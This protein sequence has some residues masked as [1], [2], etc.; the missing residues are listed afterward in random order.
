M[1]ADDKS[2]L[3][4]FHG[5]PWSTSLKLTSLFV[6]LVLIGVAIAVGRTG[7]WAG[8][9]ASSASLSLLVGMLLF[10][11][12]GYAVEGSALVVRRLL[13]NTRLSLLGLVSAK[14]DPLAMESSL[15]TFGNGGGFSFTGRYRNKRLGSYR[16]LVT[17]PARSVVLR[18]PERTVVVSRGSPEAFVRE[19]LGRV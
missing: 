12:R 8:W 9:L 19:L 5:A 4:G 10:T 13:W 1:K 17:D 3:G 6:S 15:R 14:A 18:W 7:G 16:A 2:D 11:V